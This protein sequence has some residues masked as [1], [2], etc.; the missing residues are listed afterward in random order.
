MI[1]KYIHSSSTKFK[2]NILLL[3]CILTFNNLISILRKTLKN[4]ITVHILHELYLINF[5][6]M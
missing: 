4:K 3:N 6:N 5:E 1:K 2:P